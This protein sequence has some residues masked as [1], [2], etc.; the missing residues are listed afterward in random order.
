VRTAIAGRFEINKDKA[1]EFRFYR[2]AA[3]GELI[4]PAGHRKPRRMPKKSLR[5]LKK[6]APDA[7]VI[8]LCEEPAKTWRALDGSEARPWSR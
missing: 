5:R 3:N 8:D 6:T 4:A 2:K 7:K 1:G